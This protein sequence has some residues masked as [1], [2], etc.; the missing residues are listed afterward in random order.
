ME[1]SSWLFVGFTLLVALLMFFDLRV[2][3]SG[4]HVIG[5]RDAGVRY[6]AWVS[7][8]ALFNIGLFVWLGKE[9]GLEFLTGYIVE[10]SLSVDNIFVW[11]I[12]LSFFRVPPEYRQKVLFLG[13]IGAVIMRGLFIAVGV[14]LLNLFGWVIY[15]FGAFLIYT[16]IKLAIRKDSEVNPEQNPVLRLTRRFLPVTEEYQG[17]HFFVRQKGSLLA[18]PLFMVL[19]VVEVSDVVFAVDSIPAILAITRDPFIVWT[20]NVFAILGLRAL[21]FLVAG[22]L[23]HFRYLNI[24]LAM[25]LSFIGFKML[26][27]DIYHVPT[28]AS[29]VGVVGI[30][31]VTIL[32]SYLPAR[33]K[34]DAVV[35]N[36]VT[37]DN[38]LD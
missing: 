8:A 33:K 22:A 23:V 5:L 28:T 14:T 21:F 2:F 35:N 4:S 6:A 15:I 38:Q 11:L 31:G 25:V 32:A 37:K 24:G 34:A 7:L 9:K 18:T 12:I 27:S 10:L 30:L 20:S 19:I 26:I 29:L 36:E 3:L 13:I 1:Y 16:G 17:Q